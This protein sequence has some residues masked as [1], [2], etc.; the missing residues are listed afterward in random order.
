MPL[1]DAMIVKQRVEFAMQPVGK[2]TST[3]TA[4]NR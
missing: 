2:A 1:I 4:T 3:K